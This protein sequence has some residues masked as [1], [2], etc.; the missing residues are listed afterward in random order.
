LSIERLSVAFEE[1]S[2]LSELSLRTCSS[3]IQLVVG[4]VATGKSTLLRTLAGLVHVQQG[5]QVSGSVSWGKSPLW[6]NPQARVALVQQ[7]LGF[8]ARTVRELLASALPDRARLSPVAQREIVVQLLEG[9]DLEELLPELERAV[10]DLSPTV[11]RRLAILRA[12][13]GDPC[14]LLVDEPTAGI[15]DRSAELILADLT[16]ESRQRLLVVVTHNQAHAQKLAGEVLLLFDGKI[17]EQRSTRDFFAAPRTKAARDFVKT[18]GCV[19]PA[20]SELP[21]PW[22]TE[23]PSGFFWL[24]EQ[25]LAGLPRPGLLRDTEADLN[26]L[27][28]LGIHTLVGLEETQTVP[29]EALAAHGIAHVHFPVVDMNAPNEPD[30]LG[31]CEQVASLQRSKRA[32][33]FHCRG[34]LGRTGT[35]LAAQ[36]LFGGDRLSE[37]VRRVRACNPLCIQSQPQLE[38]LTAFSAAVER[39]RARRGFA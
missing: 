24:K 19:R 31:L 38:F 15:Y 30:T 29:A 32:V 5:A 20:R 23:I 25:E 13:A 9:A 22:E 26:A 1:R 10:V 34:G 16:R 8:Y 4:P 36:L 17:V 7:R 21:S 14:L 37:A 3:G 28:Q 2:V 39:H 27:V 11:Q 33:A 35:L 12:V 6:G 18:G